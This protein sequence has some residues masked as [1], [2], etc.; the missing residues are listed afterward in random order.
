MGATGGLE[1]MKW[2]PPSKFLL[3]FGLIGWM[4]L[5]TP[6]ASAEKAKL[7]S[8]SYR[9]YY[10]GLPS[11]EI[12]ARVHLMPRRYEIS[13]TGRSVGLLDYLFPFTS[14]VSGSGDLEDRPGTRHYSLQSTYRGRERLIQLVSQPGEP[15][16]LSI[17]PPIPVD[18]RDPVPSSMQIGALDPLIALAAAAIQPAAAKV[19]SGTPRIFN[20]KA[21]TDVYLEHVGAENLPQS[22]YSTF[23]GRAEKCVARYKTLAGGYKKS[24]F[25]GDGPPPIIQ[26]WIARLGDANFWVPVRIQANTDLAQVLVHMTVSKFE[27]T[28]SIDN[29]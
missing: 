21:R 17:N 27:P 20:G 1:V 6:A 8:F 13:A 28:N 22:Q 25:G 12:E 15:P 18:E 29:R 26:F 24:W 10:G 2:R 3:A 19:C 14:T 9:A 16:Q 5:I 4:T 11:V 23:S 7:G